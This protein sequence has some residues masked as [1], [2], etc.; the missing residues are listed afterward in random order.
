METNK[1]EITGLWETR[2]VMDGEK[3]DILKWQEDQEEEE[4]H[5]E[6]LDWPVTHIEYN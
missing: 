1:V 3:A 4:V 5:V 6:L 2:G